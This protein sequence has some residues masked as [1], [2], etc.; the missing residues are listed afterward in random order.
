M[1]TLDHS[2]FNDV[3]GS[4]AQAQKIRETA[5]AS[6]EAAAGF[7]RAVF[8]TKHLPARMKELIL[9]A[10]HASSP[11]LNETAIARHVDRARAAGASDEEVLDV[12]LS[13]VGVANH[14][15]YFAVPILLDEYRAAGMTADALLP[16]LSAEAQAIRDDFLKTRGF[17]NEQRD[18]LARLM[19]GYFG[20]LSRMSME[21]WKSGVLQPKEREFLYIAIDCSIAHMHEQG[22]RIH[23]RNA[24]RH[25]ATRE[26]IL[27]VFQLS[28]LMGT[29]SYVLGCR[30]LTKHEA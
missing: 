10:L 28:S 19:P 12:L 2:R 8:E 5:P 3:V 22:I 24:I 17:W 9:L 14:A 20:A 29:E 13:I 18:D 6:F 15:L 30:A 21:P 4:P 7:W 23:I 25:G 16:P 26:E 11:S 27:E 1:T